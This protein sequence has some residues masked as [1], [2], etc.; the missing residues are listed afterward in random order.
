MFIS[1]EQSKGRSLP[2]RIRDRAVRGK[3][4]LLDNAAGAKEHALEAASDVRDHLRDAKDHALESL[5]EAKQHAGERV[6]SVRHQAMHTYEEAKVSVG[7]HA[8]QVRGAYN[9]ALEQNPLVIGA[10]AVAAG[11]AFGLLLPSTRSEDEMMGSVR[12]SLVDQVKHVADDARQAAV[13]TLRAGTG[14]IKTHLTDV[15]SEAKQTVVDSI[16]SA[17]KAVE[18]DIES[19]QSKTAG[20]VPSG[21][22]NLK[23][24]SPQRKAFRGPKQRRWR[25]ARER[26]RNCPLRRGR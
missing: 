22:V 17:K 10:C 4:H 3:E 18:S 20:L 14:N 8:E 12:D 19:A 9:G 26:E 25:R 21:T 5:E 2:V 7:E 15:A 13:Q 16:Q 6:E 1:R 23:A 24:D 11:V